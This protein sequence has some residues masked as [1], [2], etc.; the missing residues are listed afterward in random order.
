MGTDEAGR[1]EVPRLVKEIMIPLG[2]YPSVHADDT[3]KRAVSTME[4]AHIEVGHR[5]SLPRVLLVLGSRDE[6]VGILRR[7]DILR[8][9]EPKFLVSQRMEYQKKLWAEKVEVS[10]KKVI[11][12]GCTITPV[13]DNSAWQA[14]V[15]PMYDKLSPDLQ[16]VV[17]EIRAVK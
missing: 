2:H 10:R 12:A 3:L 11:A 5:R 7:R 4:A 14:T 9:L 15:Q 13:P 6:L 1:E 8:G 17:K 16:A